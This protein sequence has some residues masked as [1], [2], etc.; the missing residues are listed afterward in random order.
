VLQNDVKIFFLGWIMKELWSIKIARLL[1]LHPVYYNCSIE[2]NTILYYTTI[3]KLILEQ[4]YLGDISACKELL[5][6]PT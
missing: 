2:S 1:I 6:R 5:E 4:A 3:Q